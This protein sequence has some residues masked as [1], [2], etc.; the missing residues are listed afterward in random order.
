MFALFDRLGLDEAL[1]VSD[2]ISA[3]VI[4][5]CSS[6]VDLHCF[7][8]FCEVEFLISLIVF[9][10]ILLFYYFNCHIWCTHIRH[11]HILSA[12]IFH[13]LNRCVW[14]LYLIA[15]TLTPGNELPLGDNAFVNRVTVRVF[16]LLRLLSFLQ[17]V[18]FCRNLFLRL[19][20]ALVGQLFCWY[21]CCHRPGC[22]FD[23]WFRKIFII[24]FTWFRWDVYWRDY[25]LRSLWLNKDLVGGFPISTTEV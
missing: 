13:D 22:L 10:L 18:T 4:L 9:W 5:V 19:V 1:L 7:V 17:F 8:G 24:D 16:M 12:S 14:L 6:Y 20:V 3:I 23:D 15:E 2:L 21:V 11:M 25:D